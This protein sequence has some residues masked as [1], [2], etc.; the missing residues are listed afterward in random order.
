MKVYRYEYYESWGDGQGIV[1][2]E[3]EEHA[4]ELMRAPYSSEYSKEKLFPD[5]IFEEIDITKPQVIDH[6]W[7]E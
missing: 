7:T 4:I 5:L 1:I 3:S 2:A 6:S